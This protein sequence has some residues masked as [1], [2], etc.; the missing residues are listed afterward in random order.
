MPLGPKAA[1]EVADGQ[2]Q[3]VDGHHSYVELQKKEAQVNFE[4]IIGL[5]KGR[6]MMGAGGE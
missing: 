1:D 3:G 2:E 5:G 6:N 4:F